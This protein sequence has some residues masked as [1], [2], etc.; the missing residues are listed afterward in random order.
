MGVLSDK[1]IS[2]VE[3]FVT[4]RGRNPYQGTNISRFWEGIGEIKFD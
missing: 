3:R 1:F 4:Q 2:D